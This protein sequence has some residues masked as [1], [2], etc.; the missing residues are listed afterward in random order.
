MESFMNAPVGISWADVGDADQFPALHR[1]Q[2]IATT[3]ARGKHV[4]P[5]AIQVDTP[6]RPPLLC[7][8]RAFPVIYVAMAHKTIRQCGLRSTSSRSVDQHSHRAR[9]LV[10]LRLV[11]VPLS[12]S[13]SP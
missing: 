10:L 12:L 9:R 11:R 6:T 4:P 1:R 2:S 13:S 5:S 8:R 3:S 7:T